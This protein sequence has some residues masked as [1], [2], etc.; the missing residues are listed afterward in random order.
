M[1][2]K[3]Q[4][5]SDPVQP[6]DGDLSQE[7]STL[8]PN[9]D[10]SGNE[11]LELRKVYRVQPDEAASQAGFLRIVDESGEDYLYPESY[12]AAVELSSEA[13]AALQKSP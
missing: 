7:F 4:I 5:K 3:K 2:A 6:K 13:L 9:A 12:F 8:D 1:V 11:D 10:D